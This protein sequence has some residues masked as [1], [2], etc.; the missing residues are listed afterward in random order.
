MIWG[1]ISRSV[2]EEN[3]LGG[4]AYKNKIRYDLTSGMLGAG[5]IELNLGGLMPFTQYSITIR[6]YSF[7][8]GVVHNGDESAVVTVRTLEAGIQEHEQKLILKLCQTNCPRVGACSF[9]S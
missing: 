4:V 5:A 6:A 1:N 7:G 8:E 9:V 3:V 2:N